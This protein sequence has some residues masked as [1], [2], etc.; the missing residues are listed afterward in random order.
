MEF[1]E[2]WTIG[3]LLMGVTIVALFTGVFYHTVVGTGYLAENLVLV[4]FGLFVLTVAFTVIAVLRVYTQQ[5]RLR[6][7]RK[8]LRLD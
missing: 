3:T 1:E 5:C 6:Y 7:R 2:L 4:G 8:S